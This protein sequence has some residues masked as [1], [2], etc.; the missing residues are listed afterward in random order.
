MDKNQV[1]KLDFSQLPKVQNEQ[2][3]NQTDY[4]HVS[5]AIDDSLNCC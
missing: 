2:K 1:M 3:T 4:D 5:D